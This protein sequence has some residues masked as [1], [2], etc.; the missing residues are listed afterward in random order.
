MRATTAIASLLAAVAC[1]SATS[2]S[3]PVLAFTSAGASSL[4]LELPTDSSLTGFINSLLADKKAS[5][6][7]KLDAI[8]LVE[9]ENL[10]TDTFASLRHSSTDSLRARSL[11]APSQIT[12]DVAPVSNAFDDLAE[13]FRKA[14]ARERTMYTTW[15]LNGTFKPLPSTKDPHMILVRAGDL[16]QNEL[17]LLRTLESLDEDSP[18]NLV[19]IAPAAQ[20]HQHGKR[21]YVAAAPSASNGNWTE[22]EG[23]IFARYQ[24]FSTP[25]ILTLLLMGGLMLPIVY[26]AVSQLA[27]VQTPDQMGVRKDPISGDK[28]TQ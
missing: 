17:P 15:N 14:C 16:R 9:A 5:P 12:F 7:C 4:P 11:D 25:L 1:V 22:P 13:R 19:I 21:Q 10:N 3:R 2:N 18:R 23:G 28:K 6:A 20:L 27:Q 24:L 26:F 8:A